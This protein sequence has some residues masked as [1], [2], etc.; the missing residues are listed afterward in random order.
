M[1]KGPRM[2]L[3]QNYSGFRTNIWLSTF[4][5]HVQL[6]LLYKGRLIKLLVFLVDEDVTLP[7]NIAQLKPC[8][9]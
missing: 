1:I 3:P 5:C 9:V 4:L 8:L 2:P 7:F 6:K